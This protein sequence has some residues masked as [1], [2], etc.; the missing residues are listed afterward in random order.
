MCFLVS[1]TLY[2]LVCTNRIVLLQVL[3]SVT[4]KHPNGLAVDWIGR[5]LYWSDNL[6]NTIEVSKLDGRY[7]K[8]LL[9]DISELRSLQVFPSKGY[10]FYTDWS[11]GAH[12]GR[13]GMDGSDPKRII[14]DGL[15][16]LYTL[17][18]ATKRGGGGGGRGSVPS[19]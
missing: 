13:L 12:V 8:V 7:R 3:H 6:L 2:D 4:L 10:L 9:N 11:Q 15:G 17:S 18:L 14:T 5:N 16:R 19:C 1:D